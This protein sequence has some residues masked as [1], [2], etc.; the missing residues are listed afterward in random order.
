MSLTVGSAFDPIWKEAG[1]LARLFPM[2][3]ARY[4]KAR[5]QQDA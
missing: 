1:C 5:N 3:Y 4:L 2:T